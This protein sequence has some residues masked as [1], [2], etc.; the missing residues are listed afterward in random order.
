MG[1][2]RAVLR[3]GDAVVMLD[4][5]EDPHNLGTAIRSL[6]AAGVDGLVLRRRAPEGRQHGQ[7]PHH[8]QQVPGHPMPRSE[9][10]SSG[11]AGTCGSW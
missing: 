1:T 11:S 8:L 7:R 4:G 6:Y 9:P 3:R 5:V 10:A 2:A